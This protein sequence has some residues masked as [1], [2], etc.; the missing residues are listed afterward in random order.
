MAASTS[1]NQRIAVI[2]LGS[3]GYGMAAVRKKY[4]RRP[5]KAIM[6]EIEDEIKE[7][8]SEHQLKFEPIP[9]MED[10]LNDLSG[11]NRPIE[12]KLFG[13]DYGTLRELAEKVSEAI[14]KNGKG[15]GVKEVES[16]VFAGNP[17]LL[18]RVDGERAS[19]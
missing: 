5:Q 15:R 2:G 13:P 16:N 9:I 6:D 14:E 17:D 4:R 8:Y 1:Q 7:H 18:I 19:A 3:M 12:V 11:S 10:E